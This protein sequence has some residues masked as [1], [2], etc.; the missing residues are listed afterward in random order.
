MTDTRRTTHDSIPPLDKLGIKGAA[1]KDKAPKSP[2]YRVEVPVGCSSDAKPAKKKTKKA[3]APR[4]ITLNQLIKLKA[5]HTMTM[6]YDGIGAGE[7]QWYHDRVRGTRVFGKF[8]E[9]DTGDW[10]D[11][12]GYLYQLG[13]HVCFRDEPLYDKAPAVGTVSNLHQSLGLGMSDDLGFDY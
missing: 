13:E 11:Y 8:R 10:S 7:V 3:R 4:R 1:T 9:G 2:A 6:Y 12:G 5:G